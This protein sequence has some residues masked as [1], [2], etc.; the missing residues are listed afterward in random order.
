MI[1]QVTARLC[2]PQAMNSLAGLFNLAGVPRPRH[3][4]AQQHHPA[5]L[6]RQQIGNQRALFLQFIFGRGD[7]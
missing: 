1:M 4:A 5:K 3:A 2:R 6:F 7:F